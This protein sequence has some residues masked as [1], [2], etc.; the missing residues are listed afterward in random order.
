MYGLLMTAEPPPARALDDFLLGRC[1]SCL[2]CSS[3]FLVRRVPFW[4]QCILRKP[5]GGVRFGRKALGNEMLDRGV[6][7]RPP[8]AAEHVGVFHQVLLGVT[9]GANVRERSTNRNKSGLVGL[10]R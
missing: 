6:L 2:V 4:R 10:G 7:N 9:F 1:V 8:P 3:G 5:P